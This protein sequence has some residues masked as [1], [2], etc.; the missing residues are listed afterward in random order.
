MFLYSITAEKI[1]LLAHILKHEYFEN[2][3]VFAFPIHNICL[4]LS[5]KYQ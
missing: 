3:F 4:Y 1:I 5:V 2:K